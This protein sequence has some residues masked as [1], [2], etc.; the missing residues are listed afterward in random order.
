[1]LLRMFASKTLDLDFVLRD[2]CCSQVYAMIILLH[3]LHDCY[4]LLLLFH[5]ANVILC[6]PNPL[7]FSSLNVDF[8]HQNFC[9]IGHAIICQGIIGI[10]KL[11]G[12][13]IVLQKRV[14]SKVSKL[15]T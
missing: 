14:T 6:L 10:I 11:G 4:M 3:C 7:S 8:V 1:M 15:V 9:S 5:T 13:R 12:K 2:I